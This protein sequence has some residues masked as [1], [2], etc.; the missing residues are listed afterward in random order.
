MDSI[1]QGLQDGS[2]RTDINPELALAAFFNFLS[3]MISRFGEMGNKVQTE[4][5]QSPQDIFSQI[6]RIFLDGLK[7]PSSK[8]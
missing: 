8:S 5:G 2:L 4:F 6:Y 3:G 7:A 1:Q